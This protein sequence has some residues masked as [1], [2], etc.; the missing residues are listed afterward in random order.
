MKRM[1]DQNRPSHRNHF[2]LRM[3]CIAAMLCMMT[4]LNSFG[5]TSTGLTLAQEIYIN[6]QTNQQKLQ[7]LD[8]STTQ[9][10]QLAQLI[11]DM[12]LKLNETVL[13]GL[14]SADQAAY[15]QYQQAHPATVSAVAPTAAQT[16][17]SL[18]AL[19]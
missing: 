15:T 7:T 4:S 1:I 5:L 10:H 16:E 18:T 6:I 2:P 13:P 9:Y 3:M 11:S 14:S 12:Q 19:K 8:P 17:S